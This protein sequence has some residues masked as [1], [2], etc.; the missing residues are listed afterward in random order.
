MS[1]LILKRQSTS[2]TK[3]GLI[4][5][6]YLVDSDAEYLLRLNQCKRTIPVSN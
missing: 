3:R 5:N 2:S 6:F 4:I 1:L